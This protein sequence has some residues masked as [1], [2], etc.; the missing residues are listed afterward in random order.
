MKQE[1]PNNYGC[2]NSQ[3]EDPYEDRIEEKM[4][5]G[6]NGLNSEVKELKIQEINKNV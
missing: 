1:R 3:R 4:A 2:I 5:G 6:I